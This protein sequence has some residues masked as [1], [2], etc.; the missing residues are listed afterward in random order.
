MIFPNTFKIMVFI[1][2]IIGNNS[3]FF[4]STTHNISFIACPKSGATTFLIV[5][6]I[7]ITP[8]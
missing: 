7:I 6:L 5:T 4:I 2:K 3:R 8:T 1:A